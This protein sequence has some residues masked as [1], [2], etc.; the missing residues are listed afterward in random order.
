[1]LELNKETIRQ[2]VNSFRAQI[3]PET[4]ASSEKSIT[5]S[6]QG[7]MGVITLDEQNS[8]ANKLSTSNM[9][10]LLDLFMEVE[11]DTSLGSL[12]IISKKPSIFIAGADISEIE[13]L[14][15]QGGD[16]AGEALMKLQAVFTYLENL[17][18]PSLAAIHGACLGGGMEL[19]L[20]CDYRMATD[21]PE[22]RIGLP[23][24]MLGVIP[25]WGGTQR[26]PRLIGLEKSLDLILSGRH[27]TGPSALKMGLVDR[28]VPKE[29]LEQKAFEFGQEL[30]AKRTKRIRE[31]GKLGLV[32][33]I[34]GGKYIVFDIARKKLLEKSKGNYPAP[35]KALEVI[36]KTYGGSL[37][38]GLRTEAEAFSELVGSPESKNLIGIFYLNESVKKDRGTD[39]EVA[40]KPVKHAAVLGAGVM[41]GGIAQ[42][43]AA[44]GVHVRMKDIQWPAIAKGLNT[45]YGLFKSRV[46]KRKMK[47]FELENAM[48]LIGGTTSYS[49][50]GQADIVVEAVVEDLE[51]KK[52]VFAELDKVTSPNA[53]LATNTSSLSVTHIAEK[54]KDKSRVVGM[55]FFNPVDKMPL[56]EVIRGKETSDQAIA[57]VFQFAKSLGKTP[58]VVKDAPGFVVNRILGPY[59]NEAAFLLLDGVE[60]EEMDGLMEKFGMPMGPCALLDEVGLDV[61]QKVAKILYGAFGERMKPANFLDTIIDK[62]RLGKKTKKGI[63]LYEGKEKS[64]NSAILEGIERKKRSADLTDE[65]VV[66]RMTYLMVNEA[67]SILS[68]DLVRR[69]S[70]IDLAMIFGT[71]FAPFRGGLLRYADSVGI[72]K[73]VSDLEI[74]NHNYGMR[75]QPCDHLR[76]LAV[77]DQ[78]FYSA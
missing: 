23:E 43:F 65:V 78:G 66:K 37:E 12:V 7:K 9:L 46:K 70:D 20:A 45:A 76:R 11:E 73:I 61:A 52:K 57:T 38:S 64:V 18:I 39:A 51:I 58:V 28:V 17:P 27:I 4:L 53:V 26:M 50:F 3:K 40:V 5:L 8:K 29:L 67:A 6:R 35:L 21:A 16:K 10:R 54:V 74:F 24:V 25:G 59:L 49:G 69:V 68:E 1:M 33:K 31:A 56:V 2:E 47:Q 30:A 14:G 75:F 19:S 60:V 71:G 13:F 22:T 32:E 34:P 63:Y 55:H 62:D 42:L 36:K 48:A 72:A 15:S 44:K 41:G 77:K